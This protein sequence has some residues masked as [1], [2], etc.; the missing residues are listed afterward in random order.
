[1]SADSSI[2]KF[3]IEL[4]FADSKAVKG[5]KDF[6]KQVDDI[7]KKID[8]AGAARSAKKAAL[9]N[10]HVK[11]REKNLDR[12]YRIEQ[13][14][15]KRL[16]ANEAR[17][18]RRRAAQEINAHQEDERRTERAEGLNRR[19]TERM[20]Q[21]HL[22]ANREDQRRTQRINLQ[23]ASDRSRD[24][25]AAIREEERREQAQSR[26]RSNRARMLVSARRRARN[27][28]SQGILGAGIESGDLN[29]REARRTISRS[30]V[31][32]DTRAIEELRRVLR[33]HNSEIRRTTRD[34][35]RLNFSQRSLNDSTRNMARQYLSVFAI[36]AGSNAINQTGQDFEGMRAAMLL[37]SGSA[38][39]ATKDL[40]FVNEEAKRLGLNLKNATDGFTKF[41]LSAQ[42]K[43]DRGET[44]QLFTGFSEFATAAGVDKF[45]YEKGLQAIQQMMNKGQ[46]MAEE[47]KNQLAEQIPGALKAFE[48]GLGKSTAEIFKM[49]EN[50]ELMAEDVL[51]KVGIAFA[52]L[53]RQGGALAAQ[54][55]STRVAQGQFMTFAQEGADTVFTNGFSEGFS[56]LLKSIGQDIGAS[57]DGLKGLGR[58]YQLFFK[59]VE[60]ASK[61]LIPILSALFS[62]I[63]SVSEALIDI[64]SSK[65]FSIVAGIGAMTLALNSATI[66]TM[67]LN[68]ALLVTLR[69][70]L[71]IPLLI[72]GVAHEIKA[73]FDDDL[74]GLVEDYFFGG[75]QIGDISKFGAM[76]EK[77]LREIPFIGDFLGDSM[78]E[79]RSEREGLQKLLKSNS[80]GDFLEGFR[81][82]TAQF[83]SMVNGKIA[84]SSLPSSSN[85]Q[86][87]GGRIDLM[88]SS[89]DSNIQTSYQTNNLN[90]FVTSG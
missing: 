78:A 80:S 8:K 61:I 86:N 76:V 31:T 34:T 28:A 10:A 36:M 77:A 53:A 12:L 2:E 87:N 46:I 60:R 33:S 84:P 69:R 71:L 63:G 68:S 72:L 47:L 45:R 27:I 57:S 42:G 66:S 81:K 51:P 90:A 64:F 43:L 75:S 48:L 18:I 17:R 58:I 37:S 40:A 82:D 11:A 9:D 5:L 59:I 44:R 30:I 55:A 23:A 21:D 24:H 38:A 1:M 50:G 65:M 83:R 16:E 26:A 73:L 4:G 19:S 74:T 3:I 88:I 85:S 39:Q 13:A 41:Q 29:G 49:M 67:A 79:G 54:L 70:L 35:N 14:N 32:G 6:L 22:R 56:Q 7:G 89:T 15:I 62:I 52:T 25:A 20:S